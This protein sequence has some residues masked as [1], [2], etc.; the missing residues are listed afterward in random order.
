MKGISRQLAGVAIVD[1]VASFDTPLGA[2]TI[3]ALG[4]ASQAAFGSCILVAHQLSGV[5]LI[6]SVGSLDS[7]LGRRTAL[8]GAFVDTPITARGEIRL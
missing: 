6:N 1:A 7:R 8:A 2:R 4:R 5:G 3:V